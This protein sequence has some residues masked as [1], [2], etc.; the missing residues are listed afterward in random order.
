VLLASSIATCCRRGISDCHLSIDIMQNL[1][2]THLVSQSELESVI[3][4][5]SGYPVSIRSLQRRMT[6]DTIP[7]V[8]VTLKDDLFSDPLVRFGPPQ[9]WP[10]SSYH[11]TSSW[12]LSDS[13]SYCSKRNRL[14]GTGT[15]Y[16]DHHWENVTP[17]AYGHKCPRDV[18]DTLELRDPWFD[19]SPGGQQGQAPA[20]DRYECLSSCDRDWQGI[21]LSA[22]LLHPY[23]YD[24][25]G[26]GIMDTSRQLRW[27]SDGHTIAAG[28]YHLLT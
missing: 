18:C 21:G 4:F 9:P 20:R 27:V 10:S 22:F 6:V 11:S 14:R 17:V 24:I 26:S 2:E 16:H 12:P 7:Y 8:S 15:R 25:W 19:N 5:L 13:S 23:E 28:N 1:T 3:D